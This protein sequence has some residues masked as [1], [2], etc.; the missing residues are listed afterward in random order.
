MRDIL[1]KVTTG[2]MIAGAALLVA[3]CGGD[4][5]VNNTT[6]ID[7]GNDVMIDANVPMEDMNA[8][9]MNAATDMNAAADTNAAATNAQ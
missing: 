7:T 3:A 5:A 4:T 9:D 1:K 6:T 2:S 8:V